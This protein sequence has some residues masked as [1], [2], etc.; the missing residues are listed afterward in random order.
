MSEIEELVKERELKELAMISSEISNDDWQIRI[1]AINKLIAFKKSDE[2]FKE[3]IPKLIEATKDESALVRLAAIP[4]LGDLGPK[5]KTSTIRLIEVLQCKEI[6]E[7][8][9]A[10]H[11]LGKIGDD[12]DL[13][14]T[15]LL[16][17]YDSNYF[18]NSPIDF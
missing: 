1:R 6:E 16:D 9:A 13:V 17:L 18:Q 2:F 11:S 7:V 15:K 3:C 12:S 14:I 5:A 4:A 8:K 10:V